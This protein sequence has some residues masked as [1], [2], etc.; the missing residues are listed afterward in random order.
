[1]DRHLIQ[2]ERE[3]RHMATADY[4]SDILEKLDVDEAENARRTS[5]Y[6]ERGQH[7]RNEKGTLQGLEMSTEERANKR[8]DVKRQIYCLSPSGRLS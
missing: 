4:W 2:C 6:N 5:W 1:M 3:F 7:Y 8:R